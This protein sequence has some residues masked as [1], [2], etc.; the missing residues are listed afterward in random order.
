M[1]I[2]EIEAMNEEIYQMSIIGRIRDLL[3]VGDGGHAEYIYEWATKRDNPVILKPP[4]R[5][6]ELFCIYCIGRKIISWI[7]NLF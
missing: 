5:T 1:F 6:S 4:I 3:G 7:M 2:G